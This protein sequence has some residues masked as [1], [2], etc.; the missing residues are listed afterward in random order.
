MASPIPM[1]PSTILIRDISFPHRAPVSIE[2]FPKS[3]QERM[4]TT[5]RQ[6]PPSRCSLFYPPSSFAR[7]PS[8]LEHILRPTGR[9]GD[10]ANTLRCSNEAKHT[11]VTEMLRL[12]SSWLG[13]RDR[14]G[15]RIGPRSTPRTHPDG[16]CRLSD[17]PSPTNPPG[18]ALG[19]T[20]DDD[21]D[22]CCTVSE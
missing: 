3:H 12:S 21:D 19:L 20:D 10:K 6:L 17:R 9:H 1:L 22:D 14:D 5:L 8:P 16:T 18:I 2:N 4:T 11:R 15:V 7:Y 13:K